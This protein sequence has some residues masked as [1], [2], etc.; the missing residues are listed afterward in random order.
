M[1]KNKKLLKKK[2]KRNKREIKKDLREI[3]SKSDGSL[4]DL[5][6]LSKRPN[7]FLSS[8]L[9]K[10]LLL[11]IIISGAAWAG[12]FFVNDGVFTSNKTLVVNFEGPDSV[13]AGEEV[14]YT[15]RYQNTGKVPIASLETK[16]NLPPGFHII[17]TIP[18]ATN[19]INEWNIGTLTSG[20]DGAITLTGIFLSEV[21][22]TQSLQSLF[23]YKPANFNSD[24]QKVETYKVS[25]EH[26]VVNMS[27]SGPE[28]S[29]S[30]DEITYTIEV[31]NTSQ[32][33]I[34]N[35]R[36]K[37]KFPE[38][39][40]LLSS[41][42]KIEQE[43]QY[44]TLTTLDPAT[45]TTIE[46]KG[47]YTSN[48]DEQQTLAVQTGFVDD[49]LFLLQ[50]EQQIITDI[51]G[52]SLVFNLIVDGAT[53]DFAANIGKTLRASIEY[54]NKGS[55]TIE[56]ISFQLEVDAPSGTPPIVWEDA[57]LRE[58]TQRSNVIT[59]TKEEIEQLE[60]LEPLQS[61]VIDITLPINES[62]GSID[63]DEFTL[64]LTSTLEKVGT[65]EG[66]RGLQASPITIQL[67][68]NASFAS[69]ARYH[70]ESGDEIGSGPLPPT[71]DETTTY[72]VYLSVSNSLHTLE[73]IRV[74]T[75]LPQDV[76]WFDVTD[77]Q[78]GS[79]HFDPVTRQLSW[80]I[81]KLPTDIPAVGSWFMVA[82][83][84]DLS[85]VGTFMK[86]TN[87]LAFEATDIVTKS[88]ITKAQEPVTT[89]I[90]DD[91]FAYGKGIVQE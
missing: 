1:K 66:S 17:R 63:N 36:V 79:M 71:V 76:T 21:G 83:N 37:P 86:L 4:P 55:E 19:G 78:I 39:F 81:D 5:T 32:K 57:D 80:D 6:K 50:K 51:L 22:S 16:L 27:V 89:E 49:E 25:V 33:P 42:P 43:K 7:S 34:Y 10:T 15:L 58:G 38:H 90:P 68:S 72:R 64:L 74:S 3:Y 2:S 12:F 88:E 56:D 8:F 18:E 52:G 87:T 29:L 28:K 45:I 13:K 53:D 40:N 75:S 73:D 91:E 23:T 60:K 44:W 67:N 77:A 20:S 62:I 85:D 65:I 14:T 35:I 70:S 84:P 31:A 59:W 61:G 41:N 54:A 82:V 24:F 48:A 26:S 47:A 9:L 30:G 46:L 11:L 69:L